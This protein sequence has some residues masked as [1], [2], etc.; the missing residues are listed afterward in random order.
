MEPNTLVELSHRALMLVLWLSLPAVLTAAAVGLAVAVVQA[1]TQ[2][3]DQ[4]I[5]QAF[6]LIAVFLVLAVSAKWAAVEIFHFADQ[7]LGSFGL[8]AVGKPL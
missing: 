4:S 1:T 3:Q 5:G 7:L 2:I 6:K 8:P